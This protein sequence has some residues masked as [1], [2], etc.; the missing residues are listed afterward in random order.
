MIE[1]SPDTPDKDVVVRRRV[2]AFWVG[3][4]VVVGWVGWCVL[5]EQS[6]ALHVVAGP[7]VRHLLSSVRRYYHQGR[8]SVRIAH[9]KHLLVDCAIL[10]LTIRFL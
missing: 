9:D 6:V 1:R 2:I 10:T 5:T 3:R 8:S 7:N 4:Q